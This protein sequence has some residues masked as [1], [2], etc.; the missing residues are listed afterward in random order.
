MT[1]AIQGRQIVVTRAVR[2]A[3]PLIEAIDAAGGEPVALP[4]LEIV[5]PADG[6]ASVREAL[7]DSS[8][9]DWLVV[10]S[11]N[12][13]RYLPGDLEFPGRIAA[14]AS[15]TRAA[16]ED[17]GLEVDL[18]AE[19]PSSMGLLNAFGDVTV[20]GRVIIAQA[21]GGRTELA[22]GL[23]ERGEAVTVVH[24]YR[25]SMPPL[26]AQ[27][28][29]AATSAAL[30]VFASPS[31]VERYVAHVGYRPNRAVAIGAVTAAEASAAGFRVTTAVAPTTEAIMDA[32]TDALSGDA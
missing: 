14:I 19:V 7:A 28:V 3:A 6:G 2:Q 11:P 15:G 29:A 22:D 26:D 9:D 17:R 30:V 18:M 20:D 31:A 1:A 25:N 12:G 8:A 13:V 5:G 27:T 32:V 24:S 21:E 16:L 23:R 4:L 10:L